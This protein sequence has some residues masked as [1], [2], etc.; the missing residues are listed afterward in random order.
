[1]EKLLSTVEQNLS[2]ITSI[3]EVV[4]DADYDSHPLACYQLLE[5]AEK[6][7]NDTQDQVT[8]QLIRMRLKREQA[9]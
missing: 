1:M 5:L 4:R 3:I 8:A 6:M 9:I 7:S 2:I